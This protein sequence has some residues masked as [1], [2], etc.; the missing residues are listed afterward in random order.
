MAEGQGLI[1][2]PNN[3]SETRLYTVTRASLLF[4]KHNYEEEKKVF[5]LMSVSS[6]RVEFQIENNYELKKDIKEPEHK[7]FIKAFVGI[8]MFIECVCLI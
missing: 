4:V 2:F 7:L 1:C 8:K 5:R 6:D 3:S